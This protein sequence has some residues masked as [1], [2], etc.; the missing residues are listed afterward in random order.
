MLGV[1]LNMEHGH[2]HSFILNVSKIGTFYDVCVRHINIH[3]MHIHTVHGHPV[4]EILALGQLHNLPQIYAR[5]QT[6]LCLFVQRVA[7]CALGEALLCPKRLHMLP[8][9]C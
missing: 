1:C 7:N 9:K 5:M 4:V 6:R 2:T 3:M 8:M